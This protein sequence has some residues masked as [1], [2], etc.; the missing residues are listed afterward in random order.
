MKK[1]VEL[2]KVLDAVAEWCPDDDGSV[3]R[4]GDLR[5]LLDEIEALPT[6]DAYPVVQGKWIENGDNQP[7]SNDKVYCCS[8]C[9]GNRRFEWQLKPFC[10]DCGADMRVNKTQI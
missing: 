3:G 2:D 1:Y 10:E 6:V 9:N 5:D 7:T 4:I 8:N